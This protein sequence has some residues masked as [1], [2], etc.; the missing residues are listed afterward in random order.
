MSYA[1]NWFTGLGLELS[2]RGGDFGPIAKGGVAWQYALFFEG[3]ATGGH[4]VYG[5]VTQQ[6]VT[7]IDR[8]LGVTWKSVPEAQTALGMAFRAS[9][10]IVDISPDF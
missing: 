5:T 10:R 7:I 9:H 2:P 8:Q 1:K 4:V 6:G 3:G